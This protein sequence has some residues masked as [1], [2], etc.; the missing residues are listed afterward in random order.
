MKK[1]KVVIMHIVCD[2]LNLKSWLKLILIIQ[3][4]YDFQPYFYT[5]LTYVD[6]DLFKLKKKKLLYLHFVSIS[7]C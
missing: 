1:K 3:T 2:H 6:F 5:K 7:K 4:F